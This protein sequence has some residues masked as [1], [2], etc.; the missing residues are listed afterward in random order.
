MSSSIREDL[1]VAFKCDFLMWLDKWTKEDLMRS[2]E[3]LEIQTQSNKKMKIFNRNSI[4]YEFVQSRGDIHILFPD[5]MVW[6]T[7]KNS[8]K[9]LPIFRYIWENI[10]S[11]DVNGRKSLDTFIDQIVTQIINSYNEY[12]NKLYEASIIR[13]LLQNSLDIIGLEEH[14]D[15]VYEHGVEPHDAK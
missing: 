12:M 10:P 13:G 2:S 4:N 9:W 11:I 7:K 5:I 8:M 3:H 15:I 1:R 14:S 6:I